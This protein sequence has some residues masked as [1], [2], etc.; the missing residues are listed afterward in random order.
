MTWATLYEKYCEQPLKPWKVHV[1]K[2]QSFPETCILVLKVHIWINVWLPDCGRMKQSIFKDSFV[3]DAWNFAE[4]KWLCPLFY[5]KTSDKSILVRRSLLVKASYWGKHSLKGLG[6]ELS[7]Q[8]DV[9]Y[10]FASEGVFLG[11]AF[12]TKRSKTASMLTCFMQE[13]F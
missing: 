1:Y 11:S 9:R 6:F 2:S 8:R 4:A 5:I 13:F 3:R 10:F 12:Q 7:A